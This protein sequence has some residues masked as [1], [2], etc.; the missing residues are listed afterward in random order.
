MFFSRIFPLFSLVLLIWHSNGT[1]S[2][3][4]GV[5]FIK[6]GDFHYQLRARKCNSLPTSSELFGQHAER[7]FGTF[8]CN[9]AGSGGTTWWLLR[10]QKNV[11]NVRT[12]PLYLIWSY[13]LV[14]LGYCISFYWHMIPIGVFHVRPPRTGPVIPVMI[15]LRRALLC[16]PILKVHWYSIF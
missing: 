10:I 4:A 11:E 16:E 5:F 3:I 8:R 2:F 12:S 14:H 13:F 1:C 9:K 6:H 7:P 15:F